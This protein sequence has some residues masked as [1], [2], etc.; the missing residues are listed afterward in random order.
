MFNVHR[1]IFIEHPNH[2]QTEPAAMNGE[3]WTMNIE[4]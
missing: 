1:S 2:R 3:Q 4:Q